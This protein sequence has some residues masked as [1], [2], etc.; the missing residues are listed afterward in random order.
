MIE[1]AIKTLQVMETNP[2]DTK[3]KKSLRLGIE[4]LERERECRS[5]MPREE[6][7]LLPSETYIPKSVGRLPS[8]E[9]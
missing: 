6:W 8:D 9:T 2:F 5:N 7:L 1:E 3:W 4:A